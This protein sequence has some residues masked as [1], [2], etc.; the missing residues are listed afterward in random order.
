MLV[1]VADSNRNLS[2][3]I[4]KEIDYLEMAFLSCYWKE[5]EDYRK[6]DPSILAIQFGLSVIQTAAGIFASNAI[7]KLINPAGFAANYKTKGAWWKDFT[8]EIIEETIWEE[9]VSKAAYMMGASTGLSNLLGE[10][11]GS[12]SVVQTINSM[13]SHTSTQGYIN[14]YEQLTGNSY[15]PSTSLISSSI[16][17]FLTLSKNVDKAKVIELLRQH[18][19]QTKGSHII[20]K[21]RGNMKMINTL[22]SVIDT[23]MKANINL[24]NFVNMQ[25]KNFPA[26]IMADINF[27]SNV[28][29]AIWDTITSGG[30][31]IDFLNSK[32]FQ[33]EW[34]LL[35]ENGDQFREMY[36]EVVKKGQGTT[37]YKQDGCV[38]EK[39]NGEFVQIDEFGPKSLA[40]LFSDADAINLIDPEFITKPQITKR[41]FKDL[42]PGFISQQYE[43]F[44]GEF[45]DF[46]INEVYEKV[47]KDAN[48]LNDFIFKQD[49]SN[50]LKLSKTQLNIKDINNLLKAYLKYWNGLQEQRLYLNNLGRPSITTN[51]IQDINRQMGDVGSRVSFLLW[52]AEVYSGVVLKDM[53]ITAIK[54]QK[55]FDGLSLKKTLERKFIG[56]GTN[57]NER[58]TIIDIVSKQV[59]ILEASLTQFA[60][61]HKRITSTQYNSFVITHDISSRIIAECLNVHNIFLFDLQDMPNINYKLDTATRIY[62]RVIQ[63]KLTGVFARFKPE[64]LAIWGLKIY[65]HANHHYTVKYNKIEGGKMVEVSVEALSSGERD[66]IIHTI[67]A[68]DRGFGLGGFFSDVFGDEVFTTLRGKRI[69]IFHEEYHYIHR[70]I[71]YKALSLENLKLYPALEDIDLDV[72]EDGS[73]MDWSYSI[74]DLGARFAN[75]NDGIGFILEKLGYTTFQHGDRTKLYGPK[76]DFQCLLNLLRGMAPIYTTY[77]INDNYYRTSPEI[78]NI[79][80]IAPLLSSE[81]Y[82]VLMSALLF[83]SIGH[84]GTNIPTFESVLRD[85]SLNPDKYGVTD[86][87]ANREKFKLIQEAFGLIV[88]PDFTVSGTSGTNTGINSDMHRWWDNLRN[89]RS[90]SATNLM[91]QIF[92]E[93]TRR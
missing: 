82:D 73:Y 57:T 29:N 18:L 1:P 41:L 2:D 92:A 90:A 75:M 43:G 33:E 9:S 36:F 58:A 20:Q 30:T 13:M 55:S 15:T 39:I 23:R 54:V 59:D 24:Y 19:L 78:E 68:L 32:K 21:M 53:D 64:T 31:I 11:S 3:P 74:L 91:E 84:I 10:A 45:R 81:Q 50:I 67:K 17:S 25:A 5:F 22:Q 44:Y 48:G 63:A 56:F 69:V 89:S 83:A 38:Y 85:L 60:K 35:D 37:Y 66:S 70:G 87:L 88:N 4:Q 65:D 49:I 14:T 47:L 62:K 27:R 46:D 16:K 71:T 93:A 28:E 6:R 51:G 7:T 12:F 26:H 40:E 76:K 34:G 52:I 80:R 79:G 72:L 86:T 77:R 8:K 42:D 61:K